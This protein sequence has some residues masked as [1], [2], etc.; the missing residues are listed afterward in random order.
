MAN[1]LK[2]NVKMERRS[3]IQQQELLGLQDDVESIFN[4]VMVDGDKVISY[5]P[6]YDEEGEKVENKCEMVL[7]DGG[8]IVIEIAFE[9]LDS[10]M[11]GKSTHKL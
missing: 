8:Y 3:D 11:R 2:L 4:P 7:L 1:W 9:T 5:S 6:F 10:L